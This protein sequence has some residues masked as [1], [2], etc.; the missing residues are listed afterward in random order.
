VEVFGTDYP[1]PDG[2]AARDFIH[3]EDLGHARILALEAVDEGEQRVYS[4]AN[5]AGFTVA[6]VIQAARRITGRGA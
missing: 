4:L 1:T 3:V 6:K 5:G 2:T